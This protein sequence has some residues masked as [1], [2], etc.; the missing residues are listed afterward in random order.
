[1]CLADLAQ[2]RATHIGTSEDVFSVSRDCIDTQVLSFEE[3][4]VV[5]WLPDTNSR[6]GCFKFAIFLE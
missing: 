2:S 3:D 4:R 1:M 5:F 6:N